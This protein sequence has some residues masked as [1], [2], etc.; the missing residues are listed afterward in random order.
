MNTN[1]TPE[2]NILTKL[3]ANTIQLPM[4]TIAKLSN[5]KPPTQK[6]RG[7]IFETKTAI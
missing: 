7:I 4:G 3:I 2:N 5:K 1:Q 6:N